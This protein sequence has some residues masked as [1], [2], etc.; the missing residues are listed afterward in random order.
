MQLN[1]S[2][3]YTA[4]ALGVAS[5]GEG[6]ALVVSGGTARLMYSEADLNRAM[7]LSLGA[8]TTAGSGFASAQNLAAPRPASNL[9]P[10]RGYAFQ[11]DGT[12]LRAYVFDSHSGVLTASVLGSTG[13]PGTSQTVTTDQGGLKGV[14]TFTMLGGAT[15]DFSAVSQWNTA[16]LKLFQVKANGGLTGTDQI[17]D[18]DKSYVA[19][20][21]DT[22]SVTMGGQNYLLTLSALENGI[23]CYAI[24]AAGKAT[25]ND[26]L[27]THDMLAV[28]GPAALQV[29]EE[30]G[31]TYAV[32]AST[33]SSSL[34]VVR[35][36]AMGCLFLTD[37]VVDD[38]DTRFDHTAVLDSFTAN[39]RNFV[40]TA[41]TDSGVTVMELLPDGHLQLFA[42]GVF[43][44]GAGMAAVT[45]LEVAVNGTT[46]SVFVT[47]A[48][49]THVQK[50]DMALATLGV[51][52]DAVGGQ[53]SGTAKAD[54]IWGS[55]AD[56]TLLG[57]A[58][59]DFIFSGGGADVMTGGTGA[60]LFVMG[61][62]SDNGRITDF[63]QHSDRIDLSAWGHVYTAAALTITATSTG[64][65][66]ALNGH[67]VTVIAGHSLTPGSFLDSDFVF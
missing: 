6:L 11:T 32:F 35:V 20:V 53:A 23:T 60:D 21:S 44:T 30:A 51:Q 55:G 22:A 64:A 41:G 29:I 26:S 59:D 56:E 2:T 43:E 3:T 1:L 33:G 24:D 15:G 48:A 9:D 36:N 52:V 45:G 39:G 67:D 16:G 31:V 62:T 40:V 49:A 12:T 65:V 8:T 47:D 14:E 5:F 25:L 4:A 42:T 38:R 18:S 34:T 7:S 28:S 54:L 46:V 27:G 61:A 63:V 19:T 58:D 50:I 37:H 13:V 10:G 17:T 57:W 66:I